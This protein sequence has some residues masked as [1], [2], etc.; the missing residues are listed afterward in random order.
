MFFSI[1]EQIRQRAGRGCGLCI[2]EAAENIV[3]RTVGAKLPRLPCIIYRRQGHV[4]VVCRIKDGKD[5][6]AATTRGEVT[7]YKEG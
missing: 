3:F 1:C 6:I 4:V 2:S 5:Y 7:C